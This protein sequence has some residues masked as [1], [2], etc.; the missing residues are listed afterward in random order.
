MSCVCFQIDGPFISEDPS[1]PAHG[2]EAQQ[3]QTEKDAR[4]ALG[5]A[6]ADDLEKAVNAN[7]VDSIVFYARAML[8]YIRGW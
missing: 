2:T 5:E 4:H 6:L 3:A 7:D 8:S 1:C